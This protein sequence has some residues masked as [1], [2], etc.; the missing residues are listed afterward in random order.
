[1]ELLHFLNFKTYSVLRL[2]F[3]T[4]VLTTTTTTL[5][6]HY[7]HHCPR[8]AVPCLPWKEVMS[9]QEKSDE[10]LSDLLDQYGIR[11]GPIVGEQNDLP[12][13]LNGARIRVHNV[14]IT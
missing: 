11:H 4:A 2:Y 9:L 14:S 6:R 7:N 12:T 13:F 10:E 1:M 8:N 3:L 5:L